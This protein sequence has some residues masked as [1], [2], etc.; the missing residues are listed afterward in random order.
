MKRTF[1][2]PISQQRA[3]GAPSATRM[4][5]AS[6][7]LAIAGAFQP[8]NAQTFK[9]GNVTCAD[10]DP[11]WFECKI[12]PPNAGTFTCDG[13]TFNVIRPSTINPTNQSSF[14]WTATIGIDAV[15]A[16]G[17][18]DANVYTYSPESLGATGLVSPANCG[19]GSQQCGLSHISFCYD[20][21]LI[22][23]KTAEAKFYKKIDWTITKTA[24][25]EEASANA[26]EGAD[27]GY[28]VEVKKN[29]TFS[30]PYLVEGEITIRNIS[31]SAAT[32][33][34]EDKVGGVVAD[35]DCEQTSL[36]QGESTTCTYSAELDAPTN[37]TN[38][39]KITSL[40][41]GV[42]SVLASA[43]YSFDSPI[44]TEDSEPEE[45]KVTDTNGKT[46]TTAV[47]AT[48]EYSVNHVCS[49]EAGNYGEDGTY[50]DKFS[51][52]AT[53]L[54]TTDGDITYGSASAEVTLNCYAPL[55]SKDA[56]P[57]FKRTYSW[58]IEKSVDVP[59]WKLDPG[60]TGTS[61]YTVMVTKDQKDSD[62][63]VT[64]TISVKN[65]NPAGSMTVA[66]SDDLPGSTNLTLG[67]TGLTIAALGT[68]TCTYSADLP[69][70][71]RRLNTATATINGLAVSYTAPVDFT[72]VLPTTV[73]GY[74][75]INVT[76]DADDGVNQG[77]GPISS[78]Q[79]FTYTAERTCA[80]TIKDYWDKKTRHNVA[81]ITET[82]AK[83][84]KD[85]T[86]ECTLPPN[87]TLNMIKDAVPAWE[88]DWGWTIEKAADQTSINP[89]SID[90]T[91][92]VN[93]DVTVTPT[94][95][96]LFKV[97]GSVN[98]TNAD[99]TEPASI[100]SL[101]DAL[102]PGNIG[103]NLNCGITLPYTL[104][105]GATLTCTYDRTLSPAEAQ[106]AGLPPA[107]ESTVVL[108]NKAT[109]VTTDDFYGTQ[110]F[111]A[112]WSATFANPDPETDK[113]VDITDTN[114]AEPLATQ[115]CGV[116]GVKVFE[117]PL[118]VGPY[119]ECGDYT[120]HNVASLK[121]DDGKMPTAEWT[122]DVKVPCVGCT[123]TP[124][125]WK[126]HSAYG[127]AP[128]DPAW[129]KLGNAD[130]DETSEVQ[131]EGFF[132]SGQTYYQVLWTSSQG[133][134]AYYILGRAYIAAQLNILGG[135]GS[136]PAV[137]GALKAAEGLFKK[138]KPDQVAALKANDSV[139]KDFITAA[140]TLDAFN[141]GLTGPG[142]CSEDRFSAVK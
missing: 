109:A 39:A 16:K 38:T 35:V 140:G 28:K 46:W 110:T 72:G 108:T 94:V 133:G 99:H 80:R 61:T 12:D 4:L 2:T 107:Q 76:D 124:G 125:Y 127:P 58:T 100:T 22:A 65:P 40:T 44:L 130:N 116:G 33:E 75:E 26:G 141:N 13:V 54:N 137:D 25:P 41:L 48:W 31:A 47:G 117:Y 49:T 79:S 85:V 106:L 138:Y 121:S 59:K 32:F 84:F 91:F 42:G 19:G 68:G 122:I 105:G 113:C 15:I 77:W 82:G 74:P 131:D 111:T 97:S 7:L 83:A 11:T 132:L 64:G 69:D 52:V 1:I 104:A 88:R 55:V 81:T 29:E 142:H 87:A 27:F 118:T 73:Y 139:R 6:L 14:D 92:L 62:F 24:L 66:L 101:S 3:R 30:G 53:I 60:Q 10:L 90:Q 93:Y 20:K 17:G 9:S 126:T 103:I 43:N 50:S 129:M 56:T 67:C 114:L 112:E 123:L 70:N 71:T 45:V 128:Y 5:G 134:N 37:G 119:Q 115:Y 78:T 96:D 135:A 98:I 95:A 8:A 136:T 120:V 86:W 63:A 36:D 23:E 18:K 21:E 89:L 51:N 57:T 34:V 102:S